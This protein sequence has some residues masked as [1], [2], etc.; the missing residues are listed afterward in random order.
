MD[1]FKLA[2]IFHSR[3][4]DGKYVT[5]GRHLKKEV[6]EFISFINNHLTFFNNGFESR[7]INIFYIINY[8]SFL[9]R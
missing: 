7:I 6:F 9:S 2:V 4:I 3:F 8:Q 1:W 5:P